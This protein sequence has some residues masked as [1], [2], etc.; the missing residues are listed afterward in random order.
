MGAGLFDKELWSAP[1]DV[2]EVVPHLLGQLT[3]V[4]GLL[5]LVLTILVYGDTAVVYCIWRA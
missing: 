3:M 2:V 5:Q 1:I 4:R